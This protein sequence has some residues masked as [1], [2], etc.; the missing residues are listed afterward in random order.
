[1]SALA[2][3]P[4]TT[5]AA[6]RTRA[7]SGSR[8][9]PRSAGRTSTPPTT[10]S[11]WVN[12]SGLRGCFAFVMRVD[13]QNLL[14]ESNEHDNTLASG[15]SAS[16]T[17]RAPSTAE[18]EASRA[19]AADPRRRREPPS[20]RIVQVAVD[21][22]RGDVDDGRGQAGQRAA[23]DRE[24]GAGDDR[25]RHVLEAR[26]RRLAA[27][28]GRG[29]EHRAHG[30][31]QRAVDQADAE[32]RRVLAAGERVAVLGVG[33]DQGHRAR[34]QGADRVAGARAEAVD[35][36]RASPAARSRGPPRACRR[37]GP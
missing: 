23:V 25:L 9:A 33:D 4:G 10:T 15:S 26:R 3:P 37:R 30:A 6:T 27:E 8:S 7:G 24:V 17:T 36:A 19:T 1:M 11:Q 14:F 28:V 13:P 31:R 20:R 32:A 12:V 22:D 2:A 35:A 21:V 34:Q 29:L 16:P 5:P 18:T